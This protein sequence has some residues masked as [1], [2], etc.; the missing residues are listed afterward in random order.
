MHKDQLNKKLIKIIKKEKAVLGLA[1]KSIDGSYSFYHNENLSFPAASIIKI[2]VMAEVFRQTQN[3]IISLNKT[4]ILKEKDKVK[5]AGILK[6]LKAGL[7]LT[8]KELAALMI[9]ISDN[10]A[11]NMLIDLAGINNIN[12][13]MRLHCLKKSI[14]KRKL[15]ITPNLATKNFITPNEISI[16]L[17]KLYKGRILNKFHSCLAIDILARQQYNE[18]IPKYI[19][20]VKIAHKTGEISG[21]SH[22]A[23]IIFTRYPYILVA[24]SRGSKDKYQTDEAIAQISKECFE[25][26][27]CKR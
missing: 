6:E 4:L 5:G 13:L 25:Y 2:P 27:K 9:V 12:K 11:T 16:F 21:V 19:K 20:D 24:L 1:I 3:K 14:I 23:G 7:K 26:F 15:M 22:D 10:T 8:V 18:K 17:E